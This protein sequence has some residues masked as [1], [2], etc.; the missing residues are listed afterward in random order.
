MGFSYYYA[1]HGSSIQGLGNAIRSL[2]T[3]HPEYEVMVVEMGY[4]WTTRNHDQLGNIINTPDPNYLPV[5]PEKQLEYLVDYTREVKRAGGSGVIFWEP[6][7]VSTPC[8]TP[9]GTGSAHDHVVF[10]D[11]VNTNFMENGGGRFMERH[12]YEDLEAKKLTFKV[13]MQGQ[14]VNFKS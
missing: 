13:D 4:L 3:S 12:F 11:P 8:R 1:W 5:I 7:W 6:A 10:F 14:D 2:K 9:W